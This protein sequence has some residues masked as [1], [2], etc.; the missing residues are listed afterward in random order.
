MC[1]H[2]VLSHACH[3]QNYVGDTDRIDGVLLIWLNL[4]EPFGELQDG[5]AP[6]GA[7]QHADAAVVLQPNGGQRLVGDMHGQRR[8]ALLVEQV[9]HVQATIV[10]G[11]KKHT[12]PAY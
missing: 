12:R 6:V 11:G 8:L 7:A 5:G 10:L 3:L 9:P 1:M 2:Q 4:S